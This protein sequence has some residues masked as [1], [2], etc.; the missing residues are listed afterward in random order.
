MARK[1]S[2]DYGRTPITTITKENLL[3][4]SILS[5]INGPSL[6]EIIS[7][8]E[9][10]AKELLC[11]HNLEKDWKSHFSTYEKLPRA[12]QYAVEM[13]AHLERVRDWIAE[14]D[15][16]MAAREMA[17][18]MQQ[19]M[20]MTTASLESDIIRGR[21]SLVFPSEGGKAKNAPLVAKHD[22]WQ[23]KADKIFRVNSKLS[24]YAAATLISKITKDSKHTI[25]QNIIKRY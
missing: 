18:A 25:R 5:L 4:P 6:E 20:F 21:E 8:M 23:Q 7:G 24:K 9:G 3:E 16:K 22:L 13:M 12:V 1:R 10:Q 15:A 14:N 19:L 17:L 11:F 2:K